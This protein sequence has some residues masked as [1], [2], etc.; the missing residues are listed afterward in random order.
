M[1]ADNKAKIKELLAL[2]NALAQSPEADNAAAALKADDK[3]AFVDACIRAGIVSNDPAGA[4]KAKDLFKV[5]R[6]LVRDADWGWA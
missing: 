3:S 5:C 6:K 2:A 1:V 4:K